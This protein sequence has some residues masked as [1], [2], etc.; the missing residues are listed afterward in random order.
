MDMGTK[1]SA[2]LGV[3]NKW[4]ELN[5]RLLEETRTEQQVELGLI[6]AAGLNPV[7][8]ADWVDSKP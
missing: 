2:K 8:P 3:N 1:A 5:L 4:A 7:P 6:E